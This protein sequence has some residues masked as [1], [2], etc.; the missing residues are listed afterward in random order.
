[1]E[2]YAVCK[3]LIVSLTNLI[4]NNVSITIISKS[5][6]RNFSRHYVVAAKS[7]QKL[8]HRILKSERIKKHKHRLPRIH[9][10][11]SPRESKNVC[12]QISDLRSANAFVRT[13]GVLHRHQSTMSTKNEY[14]RNRGL[15]DS[16]AISFE[17]DNLYCCW[18]EVH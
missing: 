2:V 12:A 17:L 14:S 6:I 7:R 16:M 18:I 3:I 1:M 15:K 5:K 8:I 4:F 11:L 13:S 10:M 9:E